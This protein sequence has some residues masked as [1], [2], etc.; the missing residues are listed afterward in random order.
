MAATAD[1]K[2]MTVADVEL[3]DLVSLLGQYRLQ[4]QVQ[5][6]DEP[7][8]GSF[9]GDSEAG[10]AG[11]SVYVRRDTPV[12]SLLHESCHVIC[13]T[14]DRRERLDRDAGGDDLEEAAVCYLQVV[15]ADHISGLGR[16]RLMQDMDAWGYSFRLGSTR[17]WF[18]KDADDARKFLI[19]HR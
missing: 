6:D 11:K 12:H 16:Q 4:L 1:R 18:E 5:N 7:I 10:I 9:W 17:E 15:L 19:N 2:V 3:G 8:T 13:M 14:P